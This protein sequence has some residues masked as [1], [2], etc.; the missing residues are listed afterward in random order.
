MNTLIFK[1]QSHLT[2]HFCYDIEQD[3][4]KTPGG[5]QWSSFV[6]SLVKQ[7][8]RLQDGLQDCHSDQHNDDRVSIKQENAV[9]LEPDS[10]L[11][12]NTLITPDKFA[13]PCLICN[14]R[15]HDKSALWVHKKDK[16]PT[17]KYV[18]IGGLKKRVHVKQTD[19][20]KCGL[21]FDDHDAF[22]EHIREKHSKTYHC[23]ICQT[24][25][26]TKDSLKKHRSVFFHVTLL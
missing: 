6:L 19:C 1:V 7:Y 5:Q 16:H 9:K 21:C 10:L 15:F 24:Q 11:K 25:L 20:L 3:E 2:Q 8:E 26:A 18:Y 4:I 22:K 12:L 17:R 13:S 23:D 14:I